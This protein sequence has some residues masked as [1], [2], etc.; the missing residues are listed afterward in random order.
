MLGLRFLLPLLLTWTTGCGRDREPPRP[1]DDAPAAEENATPMEEGVGRDLASVDVCT[2]VPASDVAQAVG[3]TVAAEPTDWD[4]GFGGQGCR[5]KTR[6]GSFSIYTEIG[7]VPPGDYEFLR[8]SAQVPTHDVA[9]LAD[10]AWWMDRTDRADLY[11][12]KRGDVMVW[13][14]SQT[15]DR[16]KTEQELRP[17]AEVVLARL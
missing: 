12:L 1:A 10:G 9:G 7:L 17:I 16:E 15:R 13:I 6:A 8:R 14:R 4:P 11:A 5:Y 2:L 3:G